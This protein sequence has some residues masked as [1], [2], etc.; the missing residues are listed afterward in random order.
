MIVMGIDPGSKGGI[1][2]LNAGTIIF[3]CAMPLI[4]KTDIDVCAIISAIKTYKAEFI[5]IEH[6]QAFPKMGKSQTFKF[7]ENF[8]A[9]KA[10][11]DLSGVPFTLVKP[12]EWQKKAHIGTPPKLPPKDRSLL[13]FRR[14]YPQETTKHDGIIDAVL[15]AKDF[16]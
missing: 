12:R 7:G 5:V 4:A 3:T 10:A 16:N 13:V 8:G 2:I 6:S 15:I 11:A 1:A 14:L 9:V